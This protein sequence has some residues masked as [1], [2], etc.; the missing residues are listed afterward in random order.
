M[1]IS[2]S[3]NIWALNKESVKLEGELVTIIIDEYRDGVVSVK[4]MAN[5]NEK[6]RIDRI[7][8]HES[9]IELVVCNKWA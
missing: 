1:D 5:G 2:T 7:E 4:M 9:E 6:I 8:G 3:E